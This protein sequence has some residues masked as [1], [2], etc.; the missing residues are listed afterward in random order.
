MKMLQK[1]EKSLN[2]KT[3]ELYVVNRLR[4][5]AQ[6]NSTFYEHTTLNKAK[7]YTATNLRQIFV[8]NT[9]VRNFSDN[10]HDSAKIFSMTDF[11]T[12]TMFRWQ[13]I[14]RQVLFDDSLKMA[15]L[16]EIEPVK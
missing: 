11:S 15:N 3:T 10:K 12:T 8:R 9:F 2:W 14:R 13:F 7:M 5:N 6:N 16:C 4:E 1:V